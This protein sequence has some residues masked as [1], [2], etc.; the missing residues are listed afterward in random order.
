MRACLCPKSS[1]LNRLIS[2]CFNFKI[3]VVI[4]CCTVFLH[5][6]VSAAV[7][8][9]NVVIA[10]SSEI[11][12]FQLDKQTNKVIVKQHL[13]T[14]YQCNNFRVKVPIDEYY[15]DK[16]TIDEVN[17][18]VNG[19]KDKKTEPQ[20]DYY[21][22][23]GI[24]YSDAKTC[25]FDLP[26]EKKGSRSEV[27]FEKT[28]SDP[29]YFTTVYFSDA[30]SVLNKTIVMS[31]PK[32]MKVDLKEYN[33]KG[34]NIN[35]TVTYDPQSDA[36]LITYTITNLPAQV[37]ESLTP[38]ASYT[39]PHILILC[40]SADLPT[41][42][43]SYFSS[44]DELYGWYHSLTSSMD[45]DETLIK[46]KSDEII[47]GIGPDFDKIKKIL[48]WVH[49]NIR[50]IAFEDGLAGFKPAKADAVLQKKYGDC[51]GMA[52]LTKELLK[53]AGFDARLCWIGT[54]HI[55]YDYSTPSIAVDNHMICAVLYGGKTYF[56]DA[57]EKYL[58]FNEYA[59]RIQGRQVL[60]EDGPKYIFAK[61]PV[62]AASQNNDIGK[63]EISISPSGLTGLVKREWT[64]EEKEG[65]FSN[66]NTI[67]KESSK[68]AFIYFL[69]NGSGNTEI[70]DFVTSDP[71]NY[72]IPL[73]VS[74]K[75]SN[76]T[77][78]SSF[79]DELYVDIN[80]QQELSGI[81]ID[82]KERVHDLWLNNKLN[83]SSETVYILPAGYSVKDLPAAID[84]TNKDYRFVMKAV[85]AGDKVT[86]KKE[87]IINNPR[88]LKENFT[89]WNGN[90]DKVKAFYNEQ[91]V[92]IKK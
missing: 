39:E 82:T 13:E 73:T 91:L 51:K 6:H 75:I 72:D 3:P 35:K 24:F 4:F 70:T 22:V 77:A 15:D 56:L 36:D 40:K 66:L 92:L 12:K 62:A 7:K 23:N 80:D 79:G 49:N 65:I 86:V 48:Y 14:T 74:Y 52:H 33:F 90:I 1:K 81:M 58:G 29:R 38:G 26:L 34:F 42:K 71:D 25:R 85:T 45:N 20:Y 31:I 61:V 57:T 68:E 8:D 76:K 88:V 11:Y 84:V 50:Y 37:Y 27:T 53:A 21:S 32:W 18:F 5:T 69:K 9:S 16:T 10:G 64:G 60:I 28:V 43:Q 78:V 30:Y 17:I 87:I 83:K 47:Q 44:L 67:K 59:E 54:N 19:E 63:A 89:E 2:C 46:S 55:A 41:G